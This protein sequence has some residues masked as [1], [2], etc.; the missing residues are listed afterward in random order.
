MKAIDLMQVS[1]KFQLQ[2]WKFYVV[3]KIFELIRLIPLELRLG[4]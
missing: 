3:T 1:V 4:K 2:Y